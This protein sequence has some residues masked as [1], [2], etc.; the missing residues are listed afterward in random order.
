MTE[1]TKFNVPE[2][3]ARLVGEAMEVQGL[4]IRRL[5][6]EAGLSPSFLSRVLSGRRKLPGDSTLLRLAE[7]L[8]V[9]PPE[10]L[11]VEAGRIQTGKQE[12]M[13]LLRATGDLSK[14]ELDQ[15]LQAVRKIKLKRTRKGKEQ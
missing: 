11:L 15:V 1:Q 2:G 3:F 14:K 13:L 10:R 4:S 7:V 12:T 5:A 9:R 6:L 8:G